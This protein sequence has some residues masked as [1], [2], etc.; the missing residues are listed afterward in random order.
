MNPHKNSRSFSQ[1]A[2]RR[3]VAGFVRRAVGAALALLVAALL[4]VPPGRAAGTPQPGRFLLIFETSSVLKKNL[5][6]VR[7]TLNDL[8]AANL[9]SEIQDNDD[10]AVW[11]VDQSLHPGQF[12]LASWDP[13]DAAMYGD[14]LGEFLGQQKYSRHV[15]LAAVQPLLNRVA[16]NS[17]RLT[18]LIFCTTQSRLL[19]TP[20][21]SGVNE[22]ITNMAAKIKGGPVPLLLVLRSYHGD[23]L[24]CSV[25]RSAPLNFPKFPAPPPE[26]APAT[27]PPV[28]A[29]V[30]PV[31]RP[32]APVVP[33]LI[34]IGTNH[35]TAT[36]PVPAPV[37]PPIA[38]PASPPVTAPT[39]PPTTAPVPPPATNE[40]ATTATP[41][42][43]V[44]IAAP[45]N[46]ALPPSP[47]PEPAPKVV[48]A[49]PT[50]P[51]PMPAPTT[52]P[53][54]APPP[55]KA[56]PVSTPILQTAPTSAP[57]P[58]ATILPPE[59]V[60][61]NPPP[62][63][64]P[65]NPTG[66]AVDGNAAEGGFPWLWVVGGGA[67]AAAALVIWLAARARRPRSSLITSTM[68]DDPRWPPRK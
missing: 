34:I 42:T 63:A 55:V 68:R 36:K 47:P 58:T 53:L 30:P 29:A 4:A 6:W 31:V 19:G 66:P 24:G 14:R 50:N 54:P 57:E 61:S 49:P 20:Y 38:A 60:A 56:P 17:E 27:N 7:Q 1:P 25:N 15:D 32:A 45:T 44:T 21:D 2:G 5:P 37:S 9:Q 35:A 65:P 13:N 22:T 62:I 8:L 33:P 23:Y 46:A 48:S 41:P 18:V 67:V 52:A 12:P 59:R 64:R 51:A 10:L 28:V 3:A 11:T 26:P 39:P 43:P 16:K 40:V